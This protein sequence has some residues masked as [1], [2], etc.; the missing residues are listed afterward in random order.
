[1]ERAD[2]GIADEIHIQDSSCPN[3]DLIAGDE[4]PRFQI[5]VIE[6][7]GGWQFGVVAAE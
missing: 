2:V 1:M 5:P 7:T 3:G 6:V 4:D